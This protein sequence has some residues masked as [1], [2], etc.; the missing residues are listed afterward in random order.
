MT[1]VPWHE[2]PRTIQV[3]IVAISAVTVILVALWVGKR[4]MAQMETKLGSIQL[5]IGQPDEPHGDNDD[6]KSLHRGLR[7]VSASLESVMASVGQMVTRKEF[8]E[9]QTAFTTFQK[10]NAEQH[11][12]TATASSDQAEAAKKYVDD[13]IKSIIGRLEEIERAI[14]A[15]LQSKETTS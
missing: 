2:D 9:F 7:E 11:L 14:E 10:A 6:S 3:L 4:F 13:V 1:A 15:H 5:S 12:K 8:E